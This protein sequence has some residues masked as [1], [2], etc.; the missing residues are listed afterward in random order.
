MGMQGSGV[1]GSGWGRERGEGG[2]KISGGGGEKR[3]LFATV[4]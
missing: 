3:R 1:L 2:M 4:P